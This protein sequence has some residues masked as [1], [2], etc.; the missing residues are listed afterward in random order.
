[1]VS[2]WIQ[3]VNATGFVNITW[4]SLVMIG[5]A[6]LLIYLAVKKNYEPLLLIPIG[7]G[8]LLVNLP[9]TG[10]ME[11]GGFLFHLYQGVKLGVYPPLIFLGVGALTDF[12]PLI[13][14]P[15]SMLLGAAAQIGIFATFLGAIK[16][17]F[18]LPEAASI[19]IIGGADGPPAIFLTS[20]LAPHLLGPV[21]VAAY[22]YMALVPIIQP[23]IMKALTSSRERRVAMEQLREVSKREKIIFP[24]VVT[25]LSVL[26]VPSASALIGCLMLGNL[27]RES[28]VTERL[29][30][31]AQNELINIVT[32]FIGFTVGATASSRR[33]EGGYNKYYYFGARCLF[34]EHSRWSTA[35]ETDVRCNGRESQPPDWRSRR[36]CSTHGC[37]SRPES[38]PG[39]R[40]RQLPAHARDGPECGRSDRVR[41][42]S[43]CS[44]FGSWMTGSPGYFERMV[45]DYEYSRKNS[46]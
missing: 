25:A 31:T 7:F 1:M 27:I 13:A 30:K 33:F 29:S 21:A 9:L 37:K 5:I 12:G 44:S 24:I 16:M 3:F 38:R 14:N 26:L 10:L 6:I 19:G 35:G 23:P 20:K 32:I 34:S 36:I 18:T 22:S 40:S 15:S 45:F 11:E 41:T 2:K 43:R 4:P 17:G 28:G 46:V 8:M 39:G 42:G